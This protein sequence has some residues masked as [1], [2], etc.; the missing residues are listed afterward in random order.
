MS[1]EELKNKI[2]K[3]AEIREKDQFVFLSPILPKSVITVRKKVEEFIVG[4]ENVNEIDFIINS[5]GGDPGDAYRIIRT[6]RKNFEKVNVIVPFWAKSAATLLSLGGSKIIMDDFGEFGPLDVQIVKEREDSP[7]YERESALVDEKSLE[8]I[9]NRSLEMFQMMFYHLYK[10]K[11]VRI[12]RGELSKQIFD[13]LYKFYG[14]LL[15]QINPYQLGNKKRKLDIGE[16]YA[17]RI[18]TIFNSDLPKERRNLLVD[19]LVNE[20][21]DHGHI[22]D[23]DIISKF[24]PNVIKPESISQEY[25]MNISELSNLLMEENIDNF[26]DFICY[27]ENNQIEDDQTGEHENIN[28]DTDGVT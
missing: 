15:K 16:K 24:L 19:Y 6:L 12:K 20:C 10:N 5:P 4:K 26:I 23:Y 18:L 21:P 3:T 28:E 9:E 11:V 27:E 25:K 1:I 14:P 22:I 2:K 8:R 7:D 13:Y 17:T